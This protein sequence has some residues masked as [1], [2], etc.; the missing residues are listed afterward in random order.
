MPLL[1]LLPLA[2]YQYMIVFARIGAILVLMPVVGESYVPTRSRLAFGLAVAFLMTPVIGPILPVQPASGFGLAALVAGELTIGLFIGICAQIVI[3]ALQT[4]GITIAYQAGLANALIFNPVSAQ[5]SSI[6]GSFLV[7]FGVTI[8]VVSDLHHLFFL[9]MRDSYVLLPPGD[10]GRVED[11]N[12][13]IVE[14]VSG[15]FSLGLRLA[16]P[17]IVVGLIFYLGIGLLSRLMPQIQIFFVAIPIQI[18]ISI[19]IMLPALS[20]IG[21]IFLDYFND[22]IGA[23][24]IR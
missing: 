23:F 10:F 4:A 3:S 22:K 20:V 12:R 19:G 17:F 13:M 9:A 21:L 14:L 2:A 7:S 24:V 5:Q 15:S 11:F 6:I 16:S 18:I 1:D 8:V